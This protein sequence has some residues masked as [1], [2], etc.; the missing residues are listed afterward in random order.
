MNKIKS[1]FVLKRKK[2][3]YP[4]SIRRIKNGSYS[5]AMTV[6][7]VA[8]A[9]AVNLIVSELPSQYTQIDISDQKLTVLSDQTKELAAGLEEDITIYYVV[10]DDNRDSNVSRLLERYDDLSSHITV[11]EKDPVLNP[12]FTSQ[13]TDETLSENSVIVTCNDAKRVVTYDSMYES[14][15]NYNY[16]TYETTGF[17]AEGQITSAI[18]AV[19]SE[20]LPK[21]Y[22]LTGHGESQINSSLAQSIEKENIETEEL[23]LVTAES[24]PEDADCLLV[25]SPASDLSEAE[26]QKLLSYLKTGGKAIVV[27]DYTGKEMPNLMSVLEYYGLSLED[28]IIMEGDSNYYIQTPYYLVPDIASTEVSA[29]MTGGSAYAFLAAAQGILV[30]EELR[31]GLSAAPVL[32]TS[33]SAYSKVDVE[34]MTTYGKED[35][36]IDGPFNVGV[37]V[38]ETV[39]L[40]EEL[41]EEAEAAI[42]SAGAS[43]ELGS[44]SGLV[45]DSDE[46][47]DNAAG[48][49]A[50]EGETEAAGAETAEDETENAE[51]ETAETKLAVYSSSMLLDASADQMVSG[52]NA[53]LVMNTLSWMC[54]HT[55]TVSVPSKSMS[56]NYLTVTSA[57]SSFWSIIVIG[58]IPGAF[59]IGGLYIWLKRRKQ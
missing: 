57:S 33:S 45:Q 6:F 29:D 49:E 24:V 38:T 37:I 55:S 14:E 30:S 53:K 47:G 17:D 21:L 56:V 2:E 35:G 4:V 28:G 5:M 34:N 12:N 43:A 7:A 31:D 40:T 16:Y 9:V 36:D 11:V 44:I 8:A 10:Q 51:I 58:I 18:A 52:G 27:T 15:F 50:A 22:T 25:A 26:A 19:S 46:A 54:G 23:N 42:E 32:T 20:D 41:L 1:L 3:R 39:E 59:L 13:Y 48:A